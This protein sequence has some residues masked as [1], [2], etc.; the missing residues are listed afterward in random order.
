MKLKSGKKILAYW[1]DG[2]I[3]GKCMETDGAK[4][5]FVKPELI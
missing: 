1:R 3:V 2:K 5:R 4:K